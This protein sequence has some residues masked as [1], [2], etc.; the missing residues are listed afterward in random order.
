[1]NVAPSCLTQFCTELSSNALPSLLLV[2]AATLAF[3]CKSRKIV[4]V[5]SLASAGSS[6]AVPLSSS[7][8]VIPDLCPP[9][10]A[11]CLAHFIKNELTSHDLKLWY[12]EAIPD[13]LDG[14]PLPMNDKERCAGRSV[15]IDKRN[16]QAVF[17]QT[18][19][20]EG[21]GAT[22]FILSYSAPT[23]EACCT[24]GGQPL[25]NSEYN[26]YWMCAPPEAPHT[27]VRT[28]CPGQGGQ[29]HRP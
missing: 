8:S 10:L 3:S 15:G 29:L 26:K 1:M 20:T 5:P 12:D 22:G 25:T 23:R 19:G 13:C 14:V 6:A 27:M 4:A 11:V 24:I 17:L 21:L 9:T 16:G 28:P 7:P 18:V 2:C